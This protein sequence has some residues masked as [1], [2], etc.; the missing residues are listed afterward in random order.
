MTRQAQ[1]QYTTALRRVLEK[2]PTLPPRKRGESWEE[3]LQRLE[4][5]LRLLE[6]AWGDWVES[7][8]RPELYLSDPYWAHAWPKAR[9][10]IYLLRMAIPELRRALKGVR[11]A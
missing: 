5:R 7:P 3:Y 2:Y 9:G 6:A 8:P 10:E 4:H 11:H 1:V